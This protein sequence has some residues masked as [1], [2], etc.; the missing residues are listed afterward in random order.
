MLEQ[1]AWLYVIAYLGATAMILLGIFALVVYR[2][3]I[4]M[5]L[6]L[7]I[8][9]AGINLFLI[10]TG[11][12]PDAVAPILIGAPAGAAMV[13]PV[14][15]ALVL[16]AIVIGVGVQA[17]ALALAVQAHRAYGTLDTQVWARRI[18][19]ETGTRVIDDIPAPVADREKH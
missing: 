13:D 3:V 1:T 2:N 7:M 5:I 17:L 14:P 15:Q 18:A 8:L 4:R 10:T 6:G 9:D 16:T 12:R 19:E 11:F